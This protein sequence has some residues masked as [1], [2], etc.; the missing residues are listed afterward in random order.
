MKQTDPK[1]MFQSIED[2]VNK[3]VEPMLQQKVLEQVRPTDVRLAVLGCCLLGHRRAGKAVARATRKAAEQTGSIVH[4]NL[5]PDSQVIDRLK[6]LPRDDVNN[7]LHRRIMDS[8]VGR[9]EGI[10]ET[11]V[12]QELFRRI[13]RGSAVLFVVTYAIHWI[14]F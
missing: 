5:R 12:R 4:S 11:I 8:L 2:Q 6:E 7:E 3:K 13:Y 1:G 14:W 10:A 9:L